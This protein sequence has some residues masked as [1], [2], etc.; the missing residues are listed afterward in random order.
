YIKELG[1]FDIAVA[2]YPEGHPECKDRC[3][4]WRH[5]AEKV[6]AGA[7][8]IFTQLF[9]DNGDFFAFRDYLRDKLHVQVPIVPGVLPILSTAQIKRF[10]GLCGATLPPHVLE[11]LDAYADDDKAAKQY[12]IDLAT[13]MC[14]ELIRNGVD[15]IHF[16]TLNHPDS[17]A[18]VMRNLRLA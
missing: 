7:D 1:G 12:G 17:T 15:G 8:V 2:G 5:L 10:C 16:Y 9:Y 11:K 6:A 13:Q 3:Q 18:A 4:D 14:D